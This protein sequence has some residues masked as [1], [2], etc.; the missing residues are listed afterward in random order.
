MEKLVLTVAT[1]GAWTS[2]DITPYVPITPEEIA[3]DVYESYKAGASIAHIHVR[4]ENGEPTMDLEYFSKTV[5]LI[6]D[7]C[8]ILINL[9]TSGDIHATDE[10]RMKPFIELKPDL[11]SY[12]CGTMNWGHKTIFENHPL[13]LE[14]LGKQMKLHGVKPEVEVFDAGMFYNSRYYVE[15]NVL[16]DPVHYQFVLGAPG[17]TKAT[18]EN[19][20]YLKSLLPENSTWSAF[21]IGKMHLPIQYATLALGGH[22]R[23]GMEDNVYYSK[24]VLAKSNADFVARTVR[25]AK[26]LGRETA[27]PDE[28]RKILG[29]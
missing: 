16:D 18:I 3:D 6:R 22:T 7:R 11:A 2:K 13:F 23:V 9:T 1:T 5:E 12:D 15:Q 29:L 27:S 17:G 25:I 24:G 8:D 19:L 26:E 20:V 14:E 21:G 28:A 4:D 10:D